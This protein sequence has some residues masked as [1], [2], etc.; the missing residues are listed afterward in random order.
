M[1]G[2][3]PSAPPVCSWRSSTTGSRVSAPGCPRPDAY[4]IRRVGLV[5]VRRRSFPLPTRPSSEKERQLLS[6]ST[7]R[8]FP[9]TPSSS[10]SGAEVRDR[11]GTADALNPWD[12]TT[13][14]GTQT[15]RH[16]LSG[17]Q[18]TIDPEATDGPSADRFASFNF[19][20]SSSRRVGGRPP[21]RRRRDGRREA[22]SPC[23]IVVAHGETATRCSHDGVWAGS[24][25][26]VV[27]APTSSPPTTTRTR[28][29]SAGRPAR[30]SGV[31]GH[32]LV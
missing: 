9:I 17:S 29:M 27:R 5:L 25:L 4:P 10:P 12:P 8:S 3:S 13:T 28:F 22:G 7:V 23:P 2:S 31:A 26:R 20:Y 15:I 30:S 21:A 32:G 11:R 18:S 1:V 24:N 6:C 19:L 14:I 16:L